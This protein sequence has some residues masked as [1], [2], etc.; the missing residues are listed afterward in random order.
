[1]QNGLNIV[2]ANG[3]G[4]RLNQLYSPY[5]IY[6]DDDRTVYV[7]D[8]KNHRIM[9]WSCGAING[10]VVAG[11]NGRGNAMNQLNYP[12]NMIVDKERNNLIICD[13]GNRRVVRWLCQNGIS[14]ESIIWNIN[15]SRLTMDN[16]GYLYISDSE[17][18]E[19]RRWKRGD[20]SGAL[21]AGGNRKGSDLSQLS[22]PSGVIIDHLDT[23]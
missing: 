20:D 8:H 17:K 12:T 6:V 5:G 22:Q 10:Q 2:G 16:D 11:G 18:N 14:G 7:I 15:C 21:V 19:V 1:M 9:K 3:E 23:V 13:Y 4:N